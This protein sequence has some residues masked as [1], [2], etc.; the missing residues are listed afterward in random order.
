GTIVNL[1]DYC[2]D[3]GLQDGYN[4]SWTAGTIEGGSS[5]SGL[6][7]QNHELIGAL[8]CGP[9]N[10][11]CSNAFGIYSK[12]YDF[13][14]LVQQYLDPQNVPSNDRCSGAI[15]LQNGVMRVDSTAYATS[16]GD[17]A[18]TCVSSFGNGLWYT[19]TPTANGTL[20]L[21]TCGSNFDTVLQAYTGS[22]NA[23]APVPQG[24]NDDNGPSCSAT[25]A[26]LSFT[27]TTGVTYHILA[28]GY[29]SAT[30]NLHMLAQLTPTSPVQ[31]ASYDFN[32][33]N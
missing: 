4:V 17:P 29:G 16:T 7:N 12:V 2:G 8:S 13:Y 11:T 33:D 27:A 24:C 25:Q 15:A 30:G 6:F 3:A 26:S 31:S 14:P 21:S 19:V 22:C 32:S 20:T 1:S 28:G 9:A 18:P 5:G 10:D 23:L